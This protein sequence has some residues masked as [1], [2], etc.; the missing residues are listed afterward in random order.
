MIVFS[1]DLASAFLERLLKRE[2]GPLPERGRVAESR[3]SVGAGDAVP[4]DDHHGHDSGHPAAGSER[5]S[6]HGGRSLHRTVD[7]APLQCQ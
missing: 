1:Y 4:V 7:A 2:V 6:S 5:A 3:S